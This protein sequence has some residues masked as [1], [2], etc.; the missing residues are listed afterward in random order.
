MSKIKLSFSLLLA[1]ILVGMLSN[2]AFAKS[3]FSFAA[4]QNADNTY[5]VTFKSLSTDKAGTVYSVTL[6][7]AN[8]AEVGTPQGFTT[9]ADGSQ[10][11]TLFTPKLTVNA[12]Y[13]V[14]LVNKANPTLVVASSELLVADNSNGI[15]DTKDVDHDTNLVNAN[16]TGFEGLSKKRS[17]Q[18]MHG[19]YQ[20]NTNSCASCHQTHTGEDHYLLFRDGT[21]STCAACHDGTMGANGVFED[22]SAKS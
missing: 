3:P 1:L 14:E 9:T 20:N 15:I 6:R 16:E 17:G 4:T 7:D 19:S 10:A 5:T 21:Y 11:F 8:N 13:T 2:A 18:K 12:R 22:P